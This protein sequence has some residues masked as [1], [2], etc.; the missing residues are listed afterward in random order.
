MWGDGLSLLGETVLLLIGWFV[1]VQ[2]RQSGF[3]CID[4]CWW[5][6]GSLLLD[7]LRRRIAK[8]IIISSSVSK[9][10]I[11]WRFGIWIFPTSVKSPMFAK[12]RSPSSCY[13]MSIRFSSV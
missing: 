1:H 6:N 8:M 11:Y 3:C 5:V 13:Q 12:L 2:L 9:K 10:S 7:R 4:T